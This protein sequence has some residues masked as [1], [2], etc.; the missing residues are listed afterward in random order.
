MFIADINAT[1]H[2]VTLYIRVKSVA[3]PISDALAMR[4]LADDTLV[5]LM[6]E[7]RTT[8]TT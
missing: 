3:K 1:M 4:I 8:V 5:N 6:G 7:Q 2:S